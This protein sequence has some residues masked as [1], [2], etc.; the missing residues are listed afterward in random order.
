M[1][2]PREHS[3]RARRPVRLPARL[4]MRRWHEGDEADSAK[5]CDDK[6]L[7]G[8]SGEMNGR[9]SI[10]FGRVGSSYAV[11]M[12]TQVVCLSSSIAK[13][14]LTSV[15]RTCLINRLYTRS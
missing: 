1:D 6:S 13:A 14:E 5:A 7:I 15:S 4:S 11:G 2:C 9:A 10:V 12:G 3:A 8:I